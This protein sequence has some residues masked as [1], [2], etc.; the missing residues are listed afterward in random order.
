MGLF[1]V[2]LLLAKV[3][4]EGPGDTHT[5]GSQDLM[6]RHNF[7]TMAIKFYCQEAKFKMT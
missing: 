5:F 4:E 1:A 3:D 6:S 7:K 2:N